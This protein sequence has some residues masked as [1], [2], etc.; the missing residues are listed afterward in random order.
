MSGT[1]RRTATVA[2][3]TVTLGIVV[4]GTATATLGRQGGG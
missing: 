2:P 4:L 3:A 1:G